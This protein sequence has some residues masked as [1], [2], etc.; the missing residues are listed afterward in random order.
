[1]TLP[2]TLQI[3]TWPLR[4]TANGSKMAPYGPKKPPEAPTRRSGRLQRHP[5]RLKKPSKAPQNPL[6]DG[7]PQKNEDGERFT[8]NG[9]N[10][11]EEKERG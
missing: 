9:E 4:E 6:K 8:G 5:T 1:M 7:P 2:K 11:D 10:E 3:G